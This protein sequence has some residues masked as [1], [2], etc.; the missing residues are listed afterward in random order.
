MFE[1][2]TILAGVLKDLI[3][4]LPSADARERAVKALQDFELAMAQGQ[5]EIDKTE[6]QST[7]LF[8]SGW[9]PFVGWICATGFLYTVVQP[10]FHFPPADLNALLS[11][12][13]GMLGLGTLRTVEKI[14]HVAS[15]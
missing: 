14:N 3:S 2:M 7:N 13:C 9:R 12:L 4:L 1:G 10:M 5:M 8:V 11:V 15:K 6:A